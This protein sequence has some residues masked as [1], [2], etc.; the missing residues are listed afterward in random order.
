M[1]ARPV[2]S[3]LP[4]TGT[5]SHLRVQLFS[6]VPSVVAFHSTALSVL[7]PP[8]VM[9]CFLVPQAVSAPP[10]PACSLLGTNLWSR[11]LGAQ[12]PPQRLSFW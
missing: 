11:G 5:L 12:H 2:A 3:P 1:A 8:P 10:N 7:L 4:N 9:H 6:Q